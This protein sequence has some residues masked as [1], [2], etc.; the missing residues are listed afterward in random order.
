[1]TFPGH[2][3]SSAKQ[4]RAHRTARVHPGLEQL[5]TEHCT[6]A[7]AKAAGFYKSKAH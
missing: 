7:S 5:M 2:P 4:L 3:T 1:M 6:G